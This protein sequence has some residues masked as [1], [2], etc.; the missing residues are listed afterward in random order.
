MYVVSESI[1]IYKMQIYQKITQKDDSSFQY[2]HQNLLN[3]I[4]LTIALNTSCQH[5]Y[6]CENIQNY[7]NHSCIFSLTIFVC[8]LEILII[9][10]LYSSLS[11]ST[12]T[13]N[14][15]ILNKN[16][17][18]H[19]LI[20]IKFYKNTIREKIKISNVTIHA[21]LLYNIKK[22]YHQL[23]VVMIIILITLA[24]MQTIKQLVIISFFTTPNPSK[25]CKK[26]INNVR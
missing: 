9:I 12:V 15:S 25:C 14:E 10:N 13:H 11:K 3:L 5:C 16:V 19:K 2:T 4:K 6:Y 22:R 20:C 8:S 21:L 26:Y 24:L 23:P 7:A 1:N 18:I 17:T